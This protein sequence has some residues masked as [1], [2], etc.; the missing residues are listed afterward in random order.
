MVTKQMEE[1]HKVLE[2]S[3][4]SFKQPECQPERISDD[5][6][7]RILERARLHIAGLK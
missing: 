7:E 3:G 2:R 6:L 5:F 4:K 1:L